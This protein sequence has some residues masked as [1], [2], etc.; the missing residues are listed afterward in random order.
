MGLY[1]YSY[2]QVYALGTQTNRQHNAQEQ[3]PA[4]LLLVK[5]LQGI[6]PGHKSYCSCPLNLKSIFAEVSLS[7][8]NISRSY[9]SNIA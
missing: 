6:H 9:V 8:Q 7:L 1:D 3:D 2:D 4:M 5:R